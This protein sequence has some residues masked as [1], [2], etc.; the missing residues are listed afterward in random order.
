MHLAS[1]SNYPGL[2]CLDFATFIEYL[3]I[4]GGPVSLGMIE[5]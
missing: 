4:I 2:S 1:L 5:T 3:E